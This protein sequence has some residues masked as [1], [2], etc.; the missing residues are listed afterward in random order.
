LEPQTTFVQIISVKSADL[1]EKKF[2]ECSAAYQSAVWAW[3]TKRA[4]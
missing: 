3:N 2:L 1:S 4:G